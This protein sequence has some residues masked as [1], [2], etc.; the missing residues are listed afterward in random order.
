MQQAL[1]NA[2]LAIANL[3]IVISTPLSCWKTAI[4]IVIPKKKEVTD[5]THLRNIRI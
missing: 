4:N 3:V 1:F 2:T 5:R